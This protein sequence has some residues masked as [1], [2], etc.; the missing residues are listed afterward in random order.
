MLT[1]N[2]DSVES[3]L[4]DE[5]FCLRQ[6]ERV[7]F[8]QWSLHSLFPRGGYWSRI[9][10]IG[11]PGQTMSLGN[12][13][14]PQSCCPNQV[15]LVQECPHTT[16]SSTNSIPTMSKQCVYSILKCLRV[17]QCKSLTALYSIFFENTH[18]MSFSEP[19]TKKNSQAPLV[20]MS[21]QR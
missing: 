12:C 20:L 15:V 14:P 19:D 11:N 7:L 10:D 1:C 18:F 21:M 8:S 2:G 6:A 5:S 3:R 16:Y 9:L 17:R 13:F 4:E